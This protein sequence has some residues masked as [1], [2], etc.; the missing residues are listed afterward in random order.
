MDLI[1]LAIGIAIGIAVGVM[2]Y[3]YLIKRDPEKLERWAAQAKS[4]GKSAGF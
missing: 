1:S 4:A 3:R 2:C